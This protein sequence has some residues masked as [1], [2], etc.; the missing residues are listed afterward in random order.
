M[1]ELPNKTF[2]YKEG[3]TM[4]CS[5]EASDNVTSGLRGLVHKEK[6]GANG[7]KPLAPE[8]RKKN[9]FFFTFFLVFL[10]KDFLV[11]RFNLAI[12]LPPIL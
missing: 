1:S 6:I 9:Y 3:L 10:F 12:I 5:I 11:L 8:E 2:F 7:T 4:Q